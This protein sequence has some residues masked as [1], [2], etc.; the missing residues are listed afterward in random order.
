VKARV[1]LGRDA[2]R[3]AANLIAFGGNDVAE[4]IATDQV[5]RLAFRASPSNATLLV[6]WAAVLSR[7]RM[8]LADGEGLRLMCEIDEAELRS[9]AR[10]H[11]R[12]M[13]QAVPHDPK[14][15]T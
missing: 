8:E 12:A 3:M 1:Y 4:R 6:F 11:R 15:V 7:T 13:P 5:K 10:L 14:R 2:C 9:I